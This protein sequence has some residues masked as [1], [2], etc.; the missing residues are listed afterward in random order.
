M[1]TKNYYTL[2]IRAKLKQSKRIYRDIEISAEATL[3]AL[4]NW[5][6]I[7]F[8]LEEGHLFGFG[9]HPG[10][11]WRSNIQSCVLRFS[12]QSTRWERGKEVVSLY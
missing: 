8:D 4:A 12:H 9:D 5:I 10:S 11:Y 2:L 7:A 1:S 3:H 6:L